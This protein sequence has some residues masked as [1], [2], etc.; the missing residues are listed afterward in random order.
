MERL[1]LGPFTLLPSYMV[2]QSVPELEDFESPLEALAFLQRNIFW[3]IGDLLLEGE[4]KYG[5]YI[6]QH[7]PPGV[8]QDML[9]RCV[10]V[11]KAYKR[12][13][14]NPNLSWTHHMVVANKRNRLKLLEEAEQQ[15]W[16]S[17]ELRQKAGRNRSSNFEDDNFA[18]SVE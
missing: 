9:D 13:E 7:A 18:G 4:K 5:D 11:S 12:S 1:N 3:W 10:A 14:R 16:T 17:G 8:S 15:G 2:M 6:W